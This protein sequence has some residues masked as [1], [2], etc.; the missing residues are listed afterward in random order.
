MRKSGVCENVKKRD[1]RS[2]SKPRWNHIALD[3][4]TLLWNALLSNFNLQSSFRVFK[5]TLRQALEYSNLCSGA[6]ESGSGVHAGLLNTGDKQQNTWIRQGVQGC[7]IQGINNGT[8]GSGMQECTGLLN[9][10]DKQW[11]TW[12][13]QGVQGCWIQGINNGTH[14]SGMQECTGLLSTWNKQQS[15]RVN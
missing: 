8:H 7:W 3:R 2:G 5:R 9:T 13:R 4:G 10:G 14:G 15:Y 1:Q 11:N 6:Q 12:I